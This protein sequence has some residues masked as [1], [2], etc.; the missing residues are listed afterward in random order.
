[1]TNPVV[2]VIVGASGDERDASRI[3]RVVRSI[4]PRQSRAHQLGG[5]RFHRPKVS[6]RVGP[7][8]DPVPDAALI[9]LDLIDRTSSYKG[10]H[11]P[12]EWGV[13]DVARRRLVFDDS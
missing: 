8:L 5:R 4:R 2:D 10:I 3:G 12:E 1:M 13:Q 7:M 9:E 11:L 6:D